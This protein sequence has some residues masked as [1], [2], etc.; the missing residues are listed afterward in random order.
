MRRIG[1]PRWLSLL[2]AS[3]VAISLGFPC[4]SCLLGL[5]ADGG[6]A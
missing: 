3:P 4:S 6:A 1:I 5:G 2:E